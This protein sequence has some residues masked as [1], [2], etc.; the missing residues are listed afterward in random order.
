MALQSFGINSSSI[1]ANV[2]VPLGTTD[3]AFVDFGAIVSSSDNDAIV[4]TG[5]NQIVNVQGIVTA[6]DSAVKLGDSGDSSEHL[7]VGTNGY[8]GSFS[9]WAVIIQASDSTIDNRGT[10][11]S[12]WG[13]GVFM[14]GATGTVTV[15][16][17]GTIEADLAIRHTS[18]TDMMV[19]NNSG[20]ITSTDAILGNFT[21]DQVTNT[22]R[23]IGAITLY[24]GNDVYS[25]AAGHLTGK[26]LMG[27]GNDIATG[28]VDNDWFEGGTEND[29]LTGNGGADKLLGQDGNDTLNGGLGNDILDGGNG[30]DTL[31]GGAG[32]DKLTG[33]ANNDFF[34]FNTALN[35]STNRDVITDFNHVADT[36]RLENA[37]FTKLGA[38]M[39]ALNPGF[40]HAGVKAADANDYVVYNR[41]T[42]ILSYDSDGNGAHAAIGF[43]QLLNK[44]MLAAN[45]FVVI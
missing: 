4:G 9:S 35:A 29:A 16:N 7:L 25:G 22:G 44:P 45:D 18:F 23:I 28:G 15:L 10:I 5:S 34:V 6:H 27:D 8:V 43:A 33:G 40:F 21:V 24:Q 17:S 12:G 20:L 11:W 31:F 14:G 32:N 3:S 1:G 2:R 26:L 30:N 39:H 41:A 36:F 37:I 38:G 19:I 42:G 13:G